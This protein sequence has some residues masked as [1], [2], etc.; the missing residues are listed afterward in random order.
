[1]QEKQTNIVAD[2]GEQGDPCISLCLVIR[3][4]C[5]VCRHEA[6]GHALS[7]SHSLSVSVSKPETVLAATNVTIL[8]NK[9]QCLL[10]GLMIFLLWGCRSE[11][12][13]LRMTVITIITQTL[14]PPSCC[15]L[16]ISLSEQGSGFWFHEKNCLST[17]WDSPPRSPPLSVGPRHLSEVM[18]GAPQGKWNT[19]F[20]TW[21]SANISHP[22]AAQTPPRARA[23]G[24]APN[25]RRRGRASVWSARGSVGAANRGWGGGYTSNRVSVCGAEREAAAARPALERQ[26]CGEPFFLF[27][28]AQSSLS[29][30]A[31]VDI[32][33]HLFPSCCKEE[34]KTRTQTWPWS[35]TCSWKYADPRR[36]RNSQTHGDIFLGGGSWGQDRCQTFIPLSRPDEAHAPRTTTLDSIYSFH[37]INGTYFHL[38]CLPNFLEIHW[39]AG[40]WGGWGVTS[41]MEKLKRMKPSSALTFSPVCA[42]LDTWKRRHHICAAKA[43]RTQHRP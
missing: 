11:A 8:A 13:P 20:C 15:G 40:G 30:D 32:T 26:S 5:N 33:A 34:K 25:P 6:G 39:L 28:I 21:A 18:T 14:P 42:T 9:V 36:R 4:E 43:T 7:S 23:S 2:R 29:V 38:F 27:F 17:Q 41:A 24:Q 37:C 31:S 35:R 16:N 1:M 19:E 22:G 10:L 12:S 3:W